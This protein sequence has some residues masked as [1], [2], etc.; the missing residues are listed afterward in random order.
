MFIVYISLAVIFGSLVYLGF[1]AF[2]TL[3]AAKPSIENL[4]VTANRVQ[5]QTDS[6]KEETDKLSF[7][8]QKLM[9]DFEKKK[10]AVNTVVFSVKQTPVE[11]KN[12]L[13][14][15]PVAALERQYKEIGRAHV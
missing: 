1:V 13:K 12:A 11:F 7:K 4:Q 8:Q 15:K 9:T 2:K 6:I 5:S 3:K 10:K 14:F